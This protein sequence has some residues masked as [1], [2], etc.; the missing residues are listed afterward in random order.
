MTKKISLVDLMTGRPAIH[1]EGEHL[2][3]DHQIVLQG[4]DGTVVLGEDSEYEDEVTRDFAEFLLRLDDKVQKAAASIDL[5]AIPRN[6][7]K[8]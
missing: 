1:R 2:N 6:R 3:P 8:R 4:P 7:R 5:N